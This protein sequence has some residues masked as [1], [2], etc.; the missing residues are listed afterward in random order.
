M[1]EIGNTIEK[2]A[3]SPVDVVVSAV[4]RLASPPLL[5][6]ISGSLEDFVRGEKHEVGK[7]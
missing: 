7:V 5:S 1:H 2:L 4:H 6:D 3:C